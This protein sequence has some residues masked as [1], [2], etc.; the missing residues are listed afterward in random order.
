MKLVLVLLAAATLLAVCAVGASA[1]PTYDGGTGVLTLPTAEIVPHGTIEVAANYQKAPFDWKGWPVARL[2]GGV[3]KNLELSVGFAHWED[4]DTDVYWH[5]GLKYRFLTQEKNK[6]DVAIGAAFGQERYDNWT[7]FDRDHT[8]VYL[9]ASKDFKSSEASPIS[10]RGT[11][12]AIYSRFRYTDGGFT[13][14]FTKP[15]VALEVMHKCGVSLGLEYRWHA[16]VEDS[17]AAPFG[18]VLRYQIPKTGLWVEGGTTNATYEGT[19]W[20][21]QRGFVGLG[22]TFNTKGY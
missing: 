21:N 16:N 10:C 17:D 22:Y 8:E 3:A 5:E 1:Y 6:V 2:V 7:F 11:V 15:Y 19:S 18:A 13:D 12:G 4:G 14:K 9:A 20:E